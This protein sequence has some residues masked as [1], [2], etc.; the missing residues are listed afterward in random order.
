MNDFDV[1]PIAEGERRA[2][3][4]L[5]AEAL[6]GSPPDDEAWAKVGPS[7]P[8][9]RTFG[10]FDGATPIG[11]TSSFATALAVPGGK[12]LPAAAVDGVAV[13]ADHTRRGV[14]T[15]LLT[16]QLRD[17]VRR[18]DLLASLHASEATIYGRFGYGVAVLGQ[19]LRIVTARAA[20][21][22]EVPSSGRVRLLDGD[23]AISRVPGLYRRIGLHRPGM[24]LRPG[25]WWPGYHDR[26]VRG[27][28]GDYRVAVHIGTDG[29]DGFVVFRAIDQRTHDD[30]ERGAVLAV[31]DLHAADPAALAG[32]WR[33][34]IGMDLTDEIRAPMRPLDEPLRAMVVDARA[35][36]TTGVGDHTWLRLLDAGAAL[37][38][39]TY[40]E[41]PPVVLGLEDRLLPENTGAYRISPDGAVRTEAPAQLRMDAEVLAMLYL[42]EWTASALAGAGR[43]TVSDPAA[44]PAADELFRTG[45]RPWCGTYF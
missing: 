3:H 35:V 31:R 38:A 37:A 26:L 5:L 25:L 7:F 19:D 29:E 10:A 9:D 23:E 14:V 41:A 43:I 21:R 44:L 1:R 34:L 45:A 27:G 22:P 15:A 18:G 28:G 2:V 32:L 16:E 20:L 8:A 11:M 12:T 40:R 39:R 24:I 17:C 30:P 36:Q 33:F 42:G 13:R 4:G 6:H